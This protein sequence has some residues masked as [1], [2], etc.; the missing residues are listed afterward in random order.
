[1]FEILNMCRVLIT[2][3]VVLTSSS[4]LSITATWDMVTQVI[5]LPTGKLQSDKVTHGVS[6]HRVLTV[7]HHSDLAALTALKLLGAAIT[8]RMRS[9]GKEVTD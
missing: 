9:L 2:D 3:H 5:Y 1:M 6:S 7:W 4:H 8:L